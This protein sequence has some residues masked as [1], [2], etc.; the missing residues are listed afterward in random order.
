M[1]HDGANVDPTTAL[2]YLATID[3]PTRF[4]KSRSVG[5]YVGLKRQPLNQDGPRFEFTLEAAGT[6]NAALERK[7][8]DIGI[9]SFILTGPLLENGS[10]E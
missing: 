9:R 8:D 3:G 2:C 6:L 7:L 5:A 10:S 4:K 1:L